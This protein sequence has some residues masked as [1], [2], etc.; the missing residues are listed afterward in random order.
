[1]RDLEAD[2]ARLKRRL[3][4]RQAQRAMARWMEASAMAAMAAWEGWNP[5][6]PCIKQGCLPGCLPGGR[7]VRWLRRCMISQTGTCKAGL[8]APVCCARDQGQVLGRDPC[9]GWGGSPL[10]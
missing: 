2:R 9:P 4:S 8:I 7:A 10:T 3:P 5:S 6:A 1:M